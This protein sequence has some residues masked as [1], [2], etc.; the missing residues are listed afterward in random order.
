M[1]TK[2]TLLDVGGTFI[3]CA[4][5]RQIP[6]RSNGS[7]EE[8]AAALREA[9]GDATD[10]AVAIPGP[11]DYRN[12]IFLM[13]HKYAAVY[14]ERFA[15][16]CHSDPSLCH[17]ERSE[18]S[19]SFRFMHDVNA[20][21]LGSVRM[22]GLQDCNCALVTI[23]TGL[24]FSYA[25]KGEVQ[26]NEKGSPVRG[27]WNR[28]CGG[29]ILED[30]I[31][32]RGIITAYLNLTGAPLQSAKGVSQLAFAGDANAIKVFSDLGKL[33]GGA[34]KEEADALGL[35]VILL[36]GQVSK[37][38]DLFIEPLA[39]QLPGVRVLPA[40]EGAVFKGLESIF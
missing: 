37:S 19:P 22:L 2:T 25:I 14:G 23:G 35:S 17:S 9:V 11:F 18:E 36:G 13:K 24:G 28:P 1:A 15:D 26:C 32:A 39:R 16:L 3:K 4:D 8:I 34:L 40:P 30:R 38:A 29:G 27:L 20:P 5:G 33:L 6:A 31:S 21:L 10:V 7:R 12:G